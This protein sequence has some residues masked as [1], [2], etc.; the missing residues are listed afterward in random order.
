[1]IFPFKENIK[2]KDTH[3]ELYPEIY[4]DGSIL[5]LNITGVSNDLL[6]PVNF[7]TAGLGSNDIIISAIVVFNLN[8]KSI[9]NVTPLKISMVI[10]HYNFIGLLVVT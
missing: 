9:L 2:L 3:Y 8:S 6:I 7:V 1:M 5:D 10:V 4:C